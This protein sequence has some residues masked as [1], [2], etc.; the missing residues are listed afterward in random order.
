[1]SASSAVPVADAAA[2]RS[3]LGSFATGVTVV[4]TAG[5][6]GEQIGL[7]ANS[8]NS[9]SLEP[10]MIL[11]SL[12]K[13]SFSL[14]AFRAAEFFAVHILGAEQEEVSGRFARRGEDKFAGLEL[15]AGPGGIPM[16]RQHAARFVCRTAYQY[17]GGDHI[18]FVGEVIDF[19]RCERAPLLFHG[20]QYG[21]LVKP[22]GAAADT[23]SE[24]H[25]GFLG[26]LLRRAFH[27]VY[28]PVGQ[29]LERRGLSVPQYFFLSRIAQAEQPTAEQLQS[30]LDTPGRY[31]SAGEIDELLQ[32][33]LLRRE[34]ERYELTPAGVEY[35]LEIASVVK[36]A[37]TDA[38]K[39]LDF[40]LRQT[41]KVALECLAT[42]A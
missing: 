17:E 21:Q 31:P 14:P 11:W 1:M 9:V 23:V 37:E 19:D 6:D 32:R 35:N 20:G 30:M 13:S 7:T 24:L 15:D 34:G 28:A 25:G 36:S 18:I 2:F 29:E 10:P 27:R 26:D 38:E 42:S 5:A 41:L 33:G 3:A 22:Q 16:L 39:S 40:E 8:F 12:A 4:T